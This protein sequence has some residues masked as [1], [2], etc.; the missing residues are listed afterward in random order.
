MNNRP[1]ALPT[2]CPECKRRPPL[3]VM[4][5]IIQAAI[6]AGPPSE[7]LMTWVCRCGHLHRITA[8]DFSQAA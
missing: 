1:L 2:R 3:R 5:A 8:A 4:P 7:V 6:A